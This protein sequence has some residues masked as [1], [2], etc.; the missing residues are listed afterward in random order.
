MSEK[1][2]TWTPTTPLGLMNDELD[3][4]WGSTDDLPRGLLFVPGAFTAGDG[5]LLESTLSNARVLLP[6]SSS[7]RLG[8]SFRVPDGW[9]NR[10]L[11]IDVRANWNAGG[12]YRVEWD[13][14]DGN[15]GTRTAQTVTGSGHTLTTLSTTEQL[16][17]SDTGRRAEFIL[18]RD[19]AHADDTST[20]NALILWV[21]IY[22]TP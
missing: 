14:S 4:L 19:S 3:H 8:V 22:P 13:L 20:S 2:F 11:T 5:A 18:L 17:A 7:P 12:N 10:D 16:A 1:L 15:L 6:N 9:E 21:R